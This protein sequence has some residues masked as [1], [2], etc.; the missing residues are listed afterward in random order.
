[1]MKKETKK[2]IKENLGLLVYVMICS[3]LVYLTNTCT[4]RNRGGKTEK[5][6]AN[7]EVVRT[8]A[9]ADSVANN[10]RLMLINNAKTR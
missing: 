7:K 2:K 4:S 6:P 9:A 5:A 1:M 3:T 8:R 10:A